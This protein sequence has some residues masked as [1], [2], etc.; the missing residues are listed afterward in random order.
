VSTQ[1]TGRVVD[2]GTTGNGV[3]GLIVRLI[4]ITMLWPYQLGKPPGNVPITTQGDGRFSIGPY[5]DPSGFNFSGSVSTARKLAL[6]IR[7]SCHRLLLRKEQDDQD[8][9]D[10]GPI[11]LAASE[12]QGFTVTLGGKGAMPVRSGNAIQLLVDNETAWGSVADA[13]VHSTKSIDIMQLE[14]D[15]PPEFNPAPSQ[16]SPEIV[17]SFDKPLDA[18]HQR[19]VLDAMDYR[20]ERLLIDKASHGQEV[21]VILPTISINWALASADLL[22]LIIPI[23]LALVTDVGNLWA[24]IFSA[25]GNGAFSNVR[26]YFNAAASTSNIKSFD[27]TLFNRVHSKLV[28]VDA[29]PTTADA[30]RLV[31]VSSPFSQSYFDS[32]NDGHHVFDP[33]RGA[34]TGEPVPVHDV[35]LSVR[36]PA[37][38]DVHD[39]F[40]LHWNRGVATAQQLAEIPVPAQVTNPSAMEYMATLQ[41][42]RT[43][44]GGA[45]PELPSGEMGVLEAY[46]RSRI[47]SF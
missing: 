47:P 8:I 40:R 25:S 45:F 4:D 32:T 16:E 17:L 36:G 20:P 13:I 27:V 18:L 34:A 30:A 11:P 37:I 19:P 35:S 44:N 7:T 2:Q 15:V 23:I 26:D 41:L 10:F 38:K 31:V 1:A 39:T 14:F 42:V 3:P 24:R 43:I 22:L 5:A 46:V 28:L 9:L 12:L 33:R 29:T 6:E 21:R